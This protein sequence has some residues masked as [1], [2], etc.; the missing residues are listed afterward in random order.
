MTSESL[1]S[2]ECN[3]RYGHGNTK[4]AK[5]YYLYMI[6]KPKYSFNTVWFPSIYLQ[7]GRLTGNILQTTSPVDN[8]TSCA[9]GCYSITQCLSFDYSQ[10][11]A[12]CIFHSNIEGP[13]LFQNSHT[14]YPFQ[15]T[16]MNVTG[17]LENV[18]QT[19]PLRT[20]GSYYHYEKL[21]TGNS[22]EFEFSDL[23]LEDSTM[24][25]INVRIRNKL[26]VVNV[27]S[28]NGFLVDL[29]PPDPGMIRNVAS[30]VVVSDGCN[31]SKAIPGCL[32]NSGIP[33][34]R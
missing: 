2:E 13:A 33:N 18:F 17:E 28:S 21:G 7:T 27:A 31:V 12:T 25:Y 9:M 26:G 20:A 14:Q 29:S 16:G 34:H 24:Y 8:L 30:D 23:V 5:H 1:E 22:T 6:N 4:K 32:D 11:E 15:N 19:A 10:Q 3:L